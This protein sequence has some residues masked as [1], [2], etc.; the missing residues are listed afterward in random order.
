M[1]QKAA[2]ENENDLMKSKL[3]IF[4]YDEILLYN[5]DLDSLQQIHDLSMKILFQVNNQDSKRAELQEKNDQ[6]E[7]VDPELPVRTLICLLWIMQI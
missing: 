1:K 3:V 4:S 7:K 6:N 2:R 5:V